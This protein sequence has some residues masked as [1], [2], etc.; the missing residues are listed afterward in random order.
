M[1][2]IRT[3]YSW[4]LEMM[5][6]SPNPAPPTIVPWAYWNVTPL[7]TLPTGTVPVM[8]VPMRFP[9]MTFPVGTTVANFV[10]KIPS[11]EVSRDEVSG[12]RGRAADQ[13]F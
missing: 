3:P 5:L 9:W 11:E 13:R 7:P 6:P 8:S 2:S 4:L 10:R 1:P 12:A